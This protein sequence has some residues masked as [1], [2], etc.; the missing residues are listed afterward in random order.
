MRQFWLKLLLTMTIWIALIG[1]GW[2]FGWI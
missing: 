2:L 1:I